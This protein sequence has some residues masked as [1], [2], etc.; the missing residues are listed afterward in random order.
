MIIEI[1]AGRHQVAADV[2]PN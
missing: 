1:R 2:S